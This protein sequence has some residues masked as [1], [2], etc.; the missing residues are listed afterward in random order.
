M[1]PPEFG[2]DAVWS[3]PLRVRERGPSYHYRR[4][5]GAVREGSG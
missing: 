2:G 5:A 1:Q 3:I 4:M